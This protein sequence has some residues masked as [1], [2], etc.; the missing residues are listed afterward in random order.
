MAQHQ[1]ASRNRQTLRMGQTQ[2]L[3]LRIVCGAERAKRCHLV[4]IVVGQRGNGLSRAADLRALS[5]VH[6]RQRRSA[7]AAPLEAAPQTPG[8]A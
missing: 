7:L 6:L 8:T 4:A 1:P 3:R 5:F 2:V